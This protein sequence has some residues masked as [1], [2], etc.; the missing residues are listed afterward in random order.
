MSTHP[1]NRC[2]T[3][4]SPQPHLH[5]AVQHEGEVSICKDPYHSIVTPQ[6]PNP[7]RITQEPIPVLHFDQEGCGPSYVQ[8]SVRNLAG[9]GAYA[10]NCGIEVTPAPEPIPLFAQELLGGFMLSKP[11]VER[12][13]ADLGTWLEKHR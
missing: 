10:D 11:E 13:H 4:D 5:P 3:C 2:P 7:H 6:N 8:F 12:L 1:D 9:H